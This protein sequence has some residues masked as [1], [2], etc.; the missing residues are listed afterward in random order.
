MERL[1]AYGGIEP[2]I[3]RPARDDL[4]GVRCEPRLLLWVLA[5]EF[6]DQ[7]QPRLAAARAQLGKGN[8]ARF[9]LR[10]ELE[11][12]LVRLAQIE[13]RIVFQVLLGLLPPRGPFARRE[14][15][16]DTRL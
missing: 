3:L 1:R 4:R 15:R 11:E 10:R 8:L 16:L 6:P 5:E 7:S 9:L 2:G 13:P 14:H 12:L